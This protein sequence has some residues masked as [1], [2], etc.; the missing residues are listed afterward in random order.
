[1]FF[2]VVFLNVTA[3]SVEE[4]KKKRS[5]E[6]AKY[7]AGTKE[8][9]KKKKKKKRG[10]VSERPSVSTL[11]DR[12]VTGTAMWNHK[13]WTGY[14][15]GRV[16]AANRYAAHLWH[17]SEST[18]GLLFV[19]AALQICICIYASTQCQRVDVE[20]KKK[21]SLRL[22]ATS[23]LKLGASLIPHPNCQQVPH[24]YPTNHLYA[25]PSFTD[26]FKE[27]VLEL[28]GVNGARCAFVHQLRPHYKEFNGTTWE[29][30]NSWEM[31]KQR[32]FDEWPSIC[33]KP[34]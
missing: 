29:T 1:M 23:C 7:S 13:S 9:Q 28:G 15:Q 34:A 32:A 25:A 17:P 30:T 6:L 3:R 10:N 21:S 18:P 27:K 2:S 26:K 14:S 22:Q 20:K 31:M 19:F 8:I 12:R 24:S 5:C 33:A 16:T 11:A 4:E